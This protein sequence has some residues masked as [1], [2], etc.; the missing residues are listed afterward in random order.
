MRGKVVALLSVSAGAGHVRAAQALEV[1][2]KQSFPG[3]QALHVDVMD[4]VSSLFRRLYA[5][6]YISVVNRHPA[7]WGYL[8]SATDEPTADSGLNKFRRAIER[9]NTGKLMAVLE[10]A[11]PDVVICTH[12]L[13]AQLLARKVAKGKFDRPVYVQVTDFDAHAF[14]ILEHITGYFVASEETACRLW[15]RGIGRERVHVT[16]IPVMPA[17]RHKMSRQ[18]CAAELGIDPEKTTFLL[19]SGGA[20]MGGMQRFAER[21]A[22]LEGRFQVLA[23]AGKNE[24]LLASLRRLALDY[25]QKVFPCGFTRTIERLMWASDLAITKPG[26][27]TTSECLAVGLPMIVICVTPGQEERNADYLLEHG[28]ALK[29]YDEAGLEY[30]VR[31]LLG[32]PSKLG[33]MRRRAAALGR[34]DAARRV[35][36]IAMSATEGGR[37]HSAVEGER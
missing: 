12:F 28:A 32:E 11:Q 16:G 2:A 22:G 8:F 13:P 20:G 1:E 17:F 6:S 21:L 34:P 23:L 5:D 31:K 9:L 25:P 19:M 35:L 37:L 10:A 15:D 14:W 29:A 30:R 36:Q 27:L 7:L 18:A 3:V 26:G 24:A 4:H 33:N